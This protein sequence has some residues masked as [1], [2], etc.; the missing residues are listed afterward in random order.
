M[1]ELLNF[2][3][4]YGWQ[5][6]L[7]ALAGVIILGILKYANAFGKIDKDKRKPIYLAISISLTLA[8]T[9]IYLLVIG[10][11]N[12][13]YY[14]AVAGAVYALNQTIYAVYETTNLKTL[15]NS[16]FEKFLEWVKTHKADTTTVSDSVEQA[17]EAETEE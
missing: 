8:G 17:T 5:I 3:A 12:F 14:L 11:F 13:T 6:A 10:Q 9:A 4:E 7:I 16:L 2:Y 15:L 1:D